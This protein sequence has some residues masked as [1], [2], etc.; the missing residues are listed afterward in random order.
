MDITGTIHSIGPEK[1]VSEK[2]TL[3]E[4]ILVDNSSQYTQHIQFQLSQARVNLIDQY[5]LGDEIK[6]H[7]NLRGKL[8]DDP[9]T[10]TTKCFNTLD[11][12]KIEG[13]ASGNGQPAQQQQSQNK[14][15][16]ISAQQNNDW[17]QPTS[18][19]SQDLPF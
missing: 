8:W 3:R 1:K 17:Q 11:A 4:F 15:Q 2:F 12:W 18:D 10:N 7:F 9:K 16:S 6:V 5:S 19:P 13:K 14:N